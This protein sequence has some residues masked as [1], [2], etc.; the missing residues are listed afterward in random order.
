MA[1]DL[2]SFSKEELGLFIFS[3]V[4]YLNGV[5]SLSQRD[6]KEEIVFSDNEKNLVRLIRKIGHGEIRVIIQDKIPIRVEEFKK[7]IK[8]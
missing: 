4:F 1:S 7:S 5:N 8:L 3:F 2:S 6:N